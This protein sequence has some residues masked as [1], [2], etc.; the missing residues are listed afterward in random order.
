MICLLVGDP[1]KL[2]ALKL[3]IFTHDAPLYTLNTAGC[4][5]NLANSTL[6][7]LHYSFVPGAAK[8]W[9]TLSLHLIL[10]RAAPGVKILSYS[11]SGRK[12][13]S[14]DFT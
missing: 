10:L 12:Y 13:K 3:F 4:P 7:F 2:P 1:F 14:V 6:H 5:L 11:Q 9:I 8:V